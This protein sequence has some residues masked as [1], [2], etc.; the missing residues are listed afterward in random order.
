ML[1]GPAPLLRNTTGS[2]LALAEFQKAYREV[3]CQRC[4]QVN[5]GRY[6]DDT[7]VVPSLVATSKQ[8]LRAWAPGSANRD[9]G[10]F[11]L[12]NTM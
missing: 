1:P 7:K 5:R 12:V 9:S 8:R 11:S 2:V 3:Q 6:E 10:T 4:G